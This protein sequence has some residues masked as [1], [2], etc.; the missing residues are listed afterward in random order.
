[1]A[2]RGAAD[3][4]GFASTP[5]FGS[6]RRRADGWTRAAA[7]GRLGGAR[8]VAKVVVGLVVVWVA[9]IFPLIVSAA[10]SRRKGPFRTARG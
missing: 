8:I 4:D 9:R 7:F 10:F 3:V 5:S 2:V 6:A 1:M